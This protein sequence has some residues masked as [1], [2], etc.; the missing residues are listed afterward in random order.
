MRAAW[1]GLA[2]VAAD[3]ATKWWVLERL[4]PGESVAV[5]PGFVYLTRIHNPGAAFGFFTHQP[6]LLSGVALF[7]LWLAWRNRQFIRRQ[8]V[9]A[10]I[11]IALGLG[12]ASGNL[13]DRLFRGAV[14]DFIDPLIWPVFNL[15]DACIVSGAAILSWFIVFRRGGAGVQDA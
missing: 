15:A 13:I 8:P 4:A 6:A 3:Q 11:G 5:V 10:R 1:V 2:V 7:L 12:G 14:V 9:G